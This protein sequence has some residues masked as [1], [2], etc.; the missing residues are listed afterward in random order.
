ML[1]K[2]DD[3]PINLLQDRMALLAALECVDLVD[4]VR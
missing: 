1:G 3:R 4:L 2:G